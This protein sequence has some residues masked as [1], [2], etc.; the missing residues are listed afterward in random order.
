MELSHI[1]APYHNQNIPP[2]LAIARY[3][4]G[5]AS[6][7]A[8]SL[9]GPLYQGTNTFENPVLFID[10]GAEFRHADEGLSVGD[11]DSFVGKLDETLDRHKNYSDLA[12]ALASIPAHFYEI[13]LHG[14]L[15]GRRDHEWVNIG[16][17]AAFLKH[18]H[19]TT[20]LHFDSA[21]TGFSAG[22]W[23]LEING[24]FSV[25]CIESA[26]ITLTGECEYPLNQ[27]TQLEPLSS[28]GLSN[29]GSGKIQ[30]KTNSPVF[31]V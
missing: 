7:R 8:L 26:K 4:H 19:Q 12:Y 14:F 2:S 27:A 9:V 20:Q 24:T 25:L 31:V 23:Q 10:G 11:G 18:R 30:L 1:T 16:E 6:H 29:A 22:Q 17:A 28:H 5:Y 3:L 21:F 15:G 13:H